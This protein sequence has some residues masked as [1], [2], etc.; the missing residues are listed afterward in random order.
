MTEAAPGST[1]R[2]VAPP[3]SESPARIQPVKLVA[4]AV[5]A[6]V[7]ALAGCGGGES[8]AGQT[9]HPAR[10]GVLRVATAFLPAPGFWEGTPPTAGFEARLAAALA[11]HLGLQRV[12][13]VQVPFG[14]IVTGHLGGA[15]IALSQITPTKEREHSVDFTTPYLAAVPGVLARAGVEATDVDELQKL[16]WVASRVSTLTPILQDQIRPDRDPVL[17]E[18]RTAALGVLRSGRADALLLDLPVAL[19]LVRAEPGRF[20]VIAQLDGDQG[21]AAA[22]PDGSPNREVVDSAIRALTADGT[23]ARLESRWLGESE[24]DVPLVLSEE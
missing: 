7:L 20:H 17:T 18:A 21:L 1:I 8:A 4:A 12:E 10:P 5:V 11:H 16:R 3:P 13:V 22:L 24:G 9:F 23:I 19:A 15:D 14:S 2:R 6:A